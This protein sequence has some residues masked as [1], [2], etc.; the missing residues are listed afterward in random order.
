VQVSTTEGFV[1]TEEIHDLSVNGSFSG[2]MWNAT[3]ATSVVDFSYINIEGTLFQF[4]VTGTSHAYVIPE[5]SS[6]IGLPLIMIATLI[7]AL[8]YRKKPPHQAATGIPL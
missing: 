6:L 3:S 4:R 8:I 5:F 7:A 1:R 2:F